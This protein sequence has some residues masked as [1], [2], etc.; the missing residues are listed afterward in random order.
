MFIYK[1]VW[2][3]PSLVGWLVG[4]LF[5]RWFVHVISRGI[6]GIVIA[7]LTMVRSQRFS[8]R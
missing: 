4:W 1:Y 8:C 6:A 2:I 3:F 7:P 5:G